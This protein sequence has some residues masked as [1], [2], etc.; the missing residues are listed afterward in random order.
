MDLDHIFA[1]CEVVMVT[2]QQQFVSENVK[3]E[4]KNGMYVREQTIVRTYGPN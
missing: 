1:A 4:L 3:K 2:T